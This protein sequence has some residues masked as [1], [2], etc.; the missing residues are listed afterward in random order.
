MRRCKGLGINPE[1]VK[2]RSG[3]VVRTQSAEAA[4]MANEENCDVQC[5][6]V[7]AGWSSTSI[8]G[9]VPGAHCF[10][11]NNKLGKVFDA[12]AKRLFK[13]LAGTVSDD[14][15]GVLAAIQVL[16][17]PL[18][19][20][21]KEPSFGPL[22]VMLCSSDDKEIML[23]HDVISSWWNAEYAPFRP[24]KDLEC[25]SSSMDRQSAELRILNQDNKFVHQQI[26]LISANMLDLNT[27]VVE[28]RE[29]VDMSLELMS[30]KLISMEG[31]LDSVIKLLTLQN[32]SSSEH[33]IYGSS[34]SHLQ[35]SV[36]LLIRPRLPRSEQQTLHFGQNDQSPI[37]SHRLVTILPRGFKTISQLYSAWYIDGIHKLPYGQM[38]DNDKADFNK[39]ANIV[40]V[41]NRFADA[42]TQIKY[43]GDHQIISFSQ[44]IRKIAQLAQERLMQ[45]LN[46]RKKNQKVAD[47]KTFLIMQPKCLSVYKALHE[48]IFK[49]KGQVRD[50]IP[51]FASGFIDHVWKGFTNTSCHKEFMFST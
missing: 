25:V 16:Y 7:A 12:F 32:G 46:T 44:T 41:M 10:S 33:I 45:V 34:S 2:E 11:A 37:D 51:E 29:T 17:Y 22:S 31:K 42:N 18:I 26:N 20:D 40:Y 5:A 49:S 15:R 19:R 43:E 39:F 1:V 24:V 28:L 4:Y 36:S 9:H 14:V 23:M 50:I 21:S 6:V 27:D 35:A 38:N 3:H 13:H 48:I 47:Q 8:H 30:E